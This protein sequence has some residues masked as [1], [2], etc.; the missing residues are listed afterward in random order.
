MA[1][2]ASPSPSNKKDNTDGHVFTEKRVLRIPKDLVLSY[3]KRH[4][5]FQSAIDSG[6]YI[7]IGGIFVLRPIAIILLEQNIDVHAF[8][9]SPKFFGKKNGLAAFC[10]CEEYIFVD[11]TPKPDELYHSSK[12]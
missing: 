9:R 3:Y 12:E 2:V 6:K 10:L 4:P 5:N 7:Y 1:P 11:R 8:F